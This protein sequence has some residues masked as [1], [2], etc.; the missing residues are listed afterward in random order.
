MAA[1]DDKTNSNNGCAH[2][3]H[4]AI[5]IIPSL[6]ER[7]I[8]LASLREPDA[9][10]YKDQVLEALLALKFGKPGTDPVPR[11]EQAV[12]A[13]CGRAELD[14]ALRREHLA[15]F[16]DWLCLNLRQEMAELG[17]Y[18]SSQGITPLTLFRKW[19]GEES[20][21]RLLPSGAMPFQRR[22]FLADMKTALAALCRGQAP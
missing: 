6:L 12:P 14:R 7:L 3:V 20:Y 4:S 5:S 10:E 19:A 16:E 18:A 1:R 9:G 17:R 22:L 11:C 13:P 21:E 8:F 15:V 2:F